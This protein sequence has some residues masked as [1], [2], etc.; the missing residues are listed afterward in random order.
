M[1]N[2][3]AALRAAVLS[4]FAISVAV[5]VWSMLTM[6][7]HILHIA[8][9]AMISLTF[10]LL[11]VYLYKSAEIASLTVYRELRLRATVDKNAGFVDYLPNG[12]P[13]LNA[14][15]GALAKKGICAR[16]ADVMTALAKLDVI[17]V[18][19]NSES[20]E[21]YVVTVETLSAMG[22]RLSDDTDSCPVRII[23]GP[24]D[25]ETGKDFDFVLTHDKI[26]HVLIAVYVSRL[27]VK[28]RR[29]ALILLCCA[30]AAAIALSVF[31]LYT[32]AAAAF[33]LWSASEIINVSRIVRKTARLTFNSVAGA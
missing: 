25:P 18:T 8:H 15:A 14:C 32:Y 6:H 33:A 27:F 26:T 13:I 31:G 10:L 22:I 12:A 1:K 21:G 20:R 2:G 16:S 30:I 9:I 5:T 17:A 23:L 7:N 4:L 11:A 3:M 29:L 28:T 24:F 19:G